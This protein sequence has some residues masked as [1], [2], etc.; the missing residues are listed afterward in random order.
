M[1]GY[2]PGLFAATRITPK[3]IDLVENR[4]QFDLEFP[5]EPGELEENL[6]EVPR[7]LEQ[8]MQEA[9]LSPL[10]GE[11]R[12]ALLRDLQFLRD[13]VARPA[14]RWRKEVIEAVLGWVES[15][16]HAPDQ[17]TDQVLPSLTPLKEA[18]RKLM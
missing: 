11:A 2:S 10:D 17:Q 16:F 18:L 9:D 5:P 8:L 12:R 6:A 7:L 4:F 13:E 1:L 14:S 3:G 15:R